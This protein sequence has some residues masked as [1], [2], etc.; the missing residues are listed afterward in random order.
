MYEIKNKIIYDYSWDF[1]NENTK[2]Y[3][4][5]YHAYPAMMIPQVARRLLNEYIGKVDLLLD[6]YCGTGTSLLEANLKGIAN[7]GFDINP[8]A[9]LIA[10]TKNTIFDSVIVKDE[11]C[12]LES[13]LFKYSF[14]E[15]E[16][17]IPHFNNIEYWFSVEILKKLSYIFKII[18]NLENKKFF[19]IPL[20]ETIRESSYTRNSEF[21][22]FRISESLLK[23]HNPDVFG[24]FLNKCKRNYLGLIELNKKISYTNTKIYNFNSCEKSPE[25]VLDDGW[26]AILTSPPYGDSKTTVAYGQY[27]RLMN[28]W[29]EFENSSKIDSLLMGGK[30]NTFKYNLELKSAENEILQVKEKDQK[31]YNELMSFLIDYNNSISNLLKSAND[32]AVA[33]YVVGNRRVKDVQIPLDKITA[34]I[35]ELN[36]FEHKKTIIR[37]IPNKRMPSKNSPSNITGSLASTMTNEYIV[38]CKKR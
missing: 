21:K 3:S 20:S 1:A 25:N 30:N 15:I 24:I 18:S 13:E 16:I 38:I 36:G 17:E 12:W 27:S 29:F 31:R 37:N 23:K 4:H 7:V 14:E 19:Y 5:C 28:Q 6:P 35:F 26:D 9:R 22:L 2:E 32:G 34:E 8:L 10:E 33:C 11:L